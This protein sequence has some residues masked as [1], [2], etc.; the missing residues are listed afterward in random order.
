MWGCNTILCTIRYHACCWINPG[1]F[2]GSQ[3]AEEVQI[4]VSHSPPACPGRGGFWC[5]EYTGCF[6]TKSV[7]GAS[8]D[9]DDRI[10]RLQLSLVR[11]TF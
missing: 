9:R 2:R 3:N 4:V 11:S 7:G 8:N 10:L 1:V 6:N 5:K